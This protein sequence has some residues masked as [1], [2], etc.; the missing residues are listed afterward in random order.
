MPLVGSSRMM[1]RGSV[2]S[3]LPITTF[4]WLPPDSVPTS[5]LQAGGAEIEARGVCAGQVELPGEIEEAVA[6]KAAERGQRDVLEDRQRQD[7][8]LALALL[9][10]IDDAARDRVGRRADDDGLAV[11]L[12]RAARRLG[13]AEQRLHQL[14]AAGADEAV[15]AEDLALAQVEARC[16][17]T[18]SDATVPAT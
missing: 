7:D 1:T 17:R 11:E 18:R 14:A 4:C 3:H 5:W 13:D 15:E 12:Q 8:A 6:R 9:R 10:H 16:R 2:A